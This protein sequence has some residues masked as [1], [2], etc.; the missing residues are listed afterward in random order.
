MSIW[1]RHAVLSRLLHVRRANSHYLSIFLGENQKRLHG[2]YS[3]TNHPSE[4]VLP[5]AN[6]IT[7]ASAV[8]RSERVVLMVL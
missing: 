5:L 7:I 6:P 4:D 3:S 8:A 2:H 1:V